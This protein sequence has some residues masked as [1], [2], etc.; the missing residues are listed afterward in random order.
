MQGSQEQM[1]QFLQGQPWLQ[2]EGQEGEGEQPAPEDFDLS[3]LDPADPQFDPSQVAERLSGLI[4][5]ATQRQVQAMRCSRSSRRAERG[6]LEPRG[7]RAR[8]GVPGLR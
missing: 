7:E 6:A 8:A 4:D 5:Q 3:F 2:Q 1:F